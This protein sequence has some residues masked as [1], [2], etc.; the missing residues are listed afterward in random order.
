[1]SNKLT[2]SVIKSI[3]KECLVEILQE[4]ISPGNLISESTA[5]LSE[6]REVSKNRKRSTRGIPNRTASALDKISFD[7]ANSTKNN[8]FERRVNEV[9]SAMTSD[10]VLG[11]I[12][13]D[14][15]KTTLQEQAGAD[16]QGP[17]GMSMPTSAAGDHAARTAASSDPM[18]LFS[19]SSSKW[20]DLAFSP[21]MPR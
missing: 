3:V 17:G 20:A 15:A 13:A 9:A 7:N 5:T 14:T 1:M 21:G 8:N 19:E 2:R 6:S 11:S 18:D 10:P 16:R 4:G 12:L